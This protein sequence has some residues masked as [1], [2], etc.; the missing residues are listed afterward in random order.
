ME[1]VCCSVTDVLAGLLTS[2]ADVVEDGQEDD[3]EEEEEEDA[4]PQ[5]QLQQRGRAGRTQEQPPPP[6]SSGRATQRASA[7]PPEPAYSQKAYTQ[8]VSLS[9]GKT[10]SARRRGALLGLVEA[11]EGA[12]RSDDGNASVSTLLSWPLLSS[13]VTLYRFG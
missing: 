8:R 13:V 9:A 10:A 1:M 7:P 11:S 12:G 4:P 5:R 2:R 6:P 3:E